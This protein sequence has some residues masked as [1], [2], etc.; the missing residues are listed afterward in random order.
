[1]GIKCCS[2]VVLWVRKF[3]LPPAQLEMIVDEHLTFDNHL[4]HVCSDVTNGTTVKSRINYLDT[5]LPAF[6][7]Y[8]II[9]WLKVVL[10][11]LSCLKLVKI[12]NKKIQPETLYKLRSLVIVKD[13]KEFSS[14]KNKLCN[15][16]YY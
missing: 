1:M 8:K 11:Y 3:A 5:P 9:R 2:C 7:K 6:S 14:S 15:K 12:K 4:N 13:N 10:K 16:Y